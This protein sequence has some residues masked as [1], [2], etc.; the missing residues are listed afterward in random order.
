MVAFFSKG[1]RNLVLLG[2]IAMGFS[3]LPSPPP[4][5][6][7]GDPSPLWDSS[8][9]PAPPPAPASC[10]NPVIDVVT[11]RGTKIN[12]RF[13]V[14][15]GVQFVGGLV[16][17]E[18]Q[19]AVEIYD[20]TTGTWQL[21]LSLP[22]EFWGCG[23][24]SVLPL[25]FVRVSIH[26]AR[27]RR[28]RI[29]APQGGSSLAPGAEEPVA[30][31]LIVQ[32]GMELSTI[33]DAFDRVAKKQ[34]LSS[35][36][37]HE[38]IDQIG[39]EIEQA[40][41]KLQSTNGESDSSVDEKSVIMELHNKLSEIGPIIQLEGSQKELNGVL[42]KYTKFLEKYLNPEISKAYRNID[43]DFHIINQIIA[44]H[45]YRHG[46]FDLGDCFINEAQEPTDATALKSPFLEMYTILE[47][48]RSRNLEPALA[49]AS[50]QRD[51]L[52]Q[53]ASSLELKLHRLQ[54]VEILQTGDRI[55]AL[56]Y[57]RTNLASFA[58]VHMAEVQKLM[59]CL[60]WAGRLDE[61]PYAELLSPTLWENVADE[62]AQQF[63][64]FL[65]QSHESPLSVAIA[66]GVQGLPTLLKLASVM[67]AKKQEWQAMKQLPVAVDLGREFQFHSI[68]VCPVS[69]E[70][71]TE[72]NPPMLMPCGHAL[73]KQSI[74]K[75]SKGST[76]TFKCPYC[77]SE[78]TVAQ[79]RQ[80]HF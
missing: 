42:F 9:P 58:S 28:N 29:P 26:W 45:F 31:C 60:L 1:E 3:H 78:A 74:L 73:C 23:E 70:Q 8:S 41:L 35:S 33:K 39:R 71:G 44:G 6:R 65:G 46:L 55:K 38:I 62:L 24:I 25:L 2:G 51:R 43:F 56:K 50:A 20:P 32:L 54:F 14:A 18:D 68:F 79:C 21:C 57:A 4:Q 48:M 69:R 63:C 77:P 64:S 5:G 47:A 11:D 61:S 53:N 15:G 12:A 19:L 66:A 72:D 30:L 17:I 59:V 10:C 40:M 27:R 16:D 22:P 36:K 76:R 34:R 13:I 37:A 52:S 67:A 49:W 75:L 7:N 80:L